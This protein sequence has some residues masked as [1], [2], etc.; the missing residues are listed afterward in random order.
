M[1]T[2]KVLLILLAALAVGLYIPESRAKI[3][4]TVEPVTRPF[5][6]WMTRGEMERIADDLVEYERGYHQFPGPR[7]FDAWMDDRY[8]DQMLTRDSWETRYQLRGGSR[9]AFR[10]ISAGPDRAFDTE[11]DLVIEGTRPDSR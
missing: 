11:D 8:Q 2:G 9:G 3:W 10:V 7:G 4:D 1:S 6:G 5:Y